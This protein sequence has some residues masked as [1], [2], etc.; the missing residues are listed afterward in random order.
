M[1]DLGAIIIIFGNIH[2]WVESF[3]MFAIWLYLEDNISLIPYVTPKFD[4]PFPYFL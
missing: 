4:G 3:A 1:D 2:I